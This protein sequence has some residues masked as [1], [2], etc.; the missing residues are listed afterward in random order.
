MKSLTAN[1]PTCA[2]LILP[3]HVHP[4]VNKS[5][6]VPD[7]SHPSAMVVSMEKSAFHHWDWINSLQCS[8]HVSH[9]SCPHMSTQL[10]ITAEGSQIFPSICNG[11][12]GKSAFHHWDWINS[13]GARHLPHNFG[14]KDEQFPFHLTAYNSMRVPGFSPPYVM[15]SWEKPASHHWNCYDSLWY[16]SPPPYPLGF[17][18]CIPF[19]FY[20][21]LSYLLSSKCTSPL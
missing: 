13:F 11:Q 5:R 1:P 20:L 8:P 17:L 6:R 9:S 15:V 12:H 18:V 7:F 3:S 10:H 4:T 2:P 16:L 14:A 19:L 21:H